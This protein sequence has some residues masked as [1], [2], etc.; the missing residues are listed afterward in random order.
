MI[1]KRIIKSYVLDSV[2]SLYVERTAK[3]DGKTKSQIIERAIK[4]EMEKEKT[5]YLLTVLKFIIA[6]QDLYIEKIKPSKFKSFYL[7]NHHQTSIK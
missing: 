5:E 6:R 1:K 3:R 4:N 7:L 2:Y